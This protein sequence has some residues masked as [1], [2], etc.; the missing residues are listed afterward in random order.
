[1]HKADY[2]DF[3]AVLDRLA[4][5]YGREKP[6]DESCQLY[7]EALR[8]ISLDAVKACASL[9]VKRSKFWPK[10][11]ELRPK[12]LAPAEAMG[13]DGAMAAAAA[14]SIRAWEARLAVGSPQ[15]RWQLLAAYLAR[16]DHEDP[17]GLVFEERMRFCRAAAERLL[18]E[19]GPEWC[20]VDTHCMHAASR[21]LGGDAIA[22]TH[23]QLTAGRAA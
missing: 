2:Q 8:D 17:A 5:T 13:D 16:T 15:V 19:F 9:H 20:V 10:P 21:L 22:H 7:W 4:A 18:Q 1:M 12:N 23:R 14:K 3:R 11:A 6:D